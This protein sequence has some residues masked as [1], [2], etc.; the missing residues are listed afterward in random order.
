MSNRFFTILVIPE[1]SSRMKR[2]VLPSWIV[3][4]SLIAGLFALALTGIMFL[5]YWYVMGQIEENKDLKLENRRLR[6]Q[7]QIFRNRMS[8]V[9]ST[10]DRI[11][12]FAT[13]LKVITNI[14][15]R[16]SMIQTLNDNLPDA[17]E[18][19]GRRPL[20]SPLPVDDLNDR[21]PEVQ[22]L[23]ADYR[24]LEDRFS[25]VQTSS[26]QVEQNL[27][28]LYELLVDQKAFLAA[29]PTRQ[30]ALGY[31]T[32]G[33]GIRKSPYGG[34][35]K[36]HEGLDI[37]N[38]PGTPILAPANGLISFA[39]QKPGYGRTVIIDHGYGLETWYGHTSKVLVKNQQKIRRGEKIA[40]VGSTGRSTGAHVH[41]E[42]R[43]NG[44][45]VDPMSYILEN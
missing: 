19:V 17:G 1:K 11:Q 32:S 7:V 44:I 42:V 39:G 10:M 34:R 23:R 3:K 20:P 40:L 33:F 13:R 29:L 43:V 41:Y 5:D 38:R 25:L 18:N 14:E 15:D 9:E 28:D 22:K 35:E 31:F 4:G 26:L 8:T 36:M 45:P 37:A 6:Q 27:Q 12:T 2:L 16:A 21:N 24:E 30:P